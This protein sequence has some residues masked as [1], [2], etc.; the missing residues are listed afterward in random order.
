MTQGTKKK[1]KKK[2]TH[3]HYNYLFTG[4]GKNILVLSIFCYGEAGHKEKDLFFLLSK[5]PPTL[6]LTIVL[7]EKEYRYIG[8]ILSLYFTSGNIFYTPHSIDVSW[9][10]MFAILY[11]WILSLKNRANYVVTDSLMANI[12]FVVSWKTHYTSMKVINKLYRWKRERDVA[13]TT[14]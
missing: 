6:S 11:K 7:Y 14:D 3:Y 4:G 13:V 5:L 8:W 12:Y 9:F 2:N 1:N 10:D